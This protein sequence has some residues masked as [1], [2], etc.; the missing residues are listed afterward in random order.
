MTSHHDTFP[1]VHILFSFTLMNKQGSKENRMLTL[2]I[3][4]GL[5]V[6][7]VTLKSP[8][9]NVASTSRMGNEPSWA[10]YNSMSFNCRSV[11]RKAIGSGAPTTSITRPSLLLHFYIASGKISLLWL[12]EGLKEIVDEANALQTCFALHGSS[13]LER[14][15][16]NPPFRRTDSKKTSLGCHFLDDTVSFSS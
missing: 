10:Q 13:L 14:Q 6:I 12:V 15:N 5:Y 16:S 11:A 4:S 3:L 8:R 7:G 1:V 2:Q 9:L